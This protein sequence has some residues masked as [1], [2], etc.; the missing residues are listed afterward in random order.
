D[1][2]GVEQ[3]SEI[4][5]RQRWAQKSAN[6]AHA[7]PIRGDIHVDVAGA[8]AHRSVHVIQNGHAHFAGCLDESWRGWMRTLWAT[9]VDGAPASA[10]FI[11]AAPPILLTLEDRKH[12]G[13]GPTFGSVVR[14]PVVVP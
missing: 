10:P 7:S 4:R 9:D 14:P 6:G 5:P 8:G 2:V 13:E 3:Q 11:L 12:V 1:H